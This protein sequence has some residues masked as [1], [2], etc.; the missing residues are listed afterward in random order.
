M[1]T[2]FSKGALGQ[3]GATKGAPHPG[4]GSKGRRDDQLAEW[5][6]T[7]PRMDTTSFMRA[8][9]GKGSLPAAPWAKQD[10]L[11]TI[12]DL[13]QILCV[14]GHF[15]PKGLTEPTACDI[16]TIFD[17]TVEVPPAAID[18]DGKIT[19][20]FEKLIRFCA[21]SHRSLVV[22][23]LRATPAN[24]TATQSG[25]VF[26][27]TQQVMGFS[28]AFCPAGEA[29]DGDDIGTFQAAEHIVL[30]PE[31]GFD[32]HARNHDPFSPALFHVF[33]RIWATC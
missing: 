31:A 18:G 30:C 32:L 14:L 26:S 29:G 16:V 22:H 6:A 27:K 23:E 20:S 25:E 1:D 2:I 19:P 21:P 8:C 28:E 7:C 24:L 11:L 13:V 33:A 15:E 5:L 10:H 4:L 3:Q 12:Q 17:K 9:F